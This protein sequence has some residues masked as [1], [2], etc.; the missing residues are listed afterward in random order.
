MPEAPHL[1]ISS[2]IVCRILDAAAA[3]GVD[4]MELYRAADIDPA[5]VRD[6]D[7]Q[8]GFDRYLRLWS[9]AIA[10]IDAPDFPLSVAGTWHR[11]HNLL[12]FVCMSSDDLGGALERASRYLR[13]V[14]NAV[15]WPVEQVGDVMVLSMDRGQASMTDTR[16]AEEFGAAEI[17]T[18]A[19]A[20]TGFDWNP[21]EVKFT[22]PEPLDASAHRTFFRGPVSFGHARC[23]IHF[24]MESLR[25]PLVKADPATVAFFVPYVEKL[26]RGCDAQ[27]TEK[28]LVDDVKRVLAERLRG[29]APALEEVAAA[30][31]MSGRTLRR[32]LQSD[33]HT[34][35]GLLDEVRLAI[36]KRHIEERAISLAEVA[37]LLGFS[38]PSAFHRAFR[39]WM[40]MTPQSYARTRSPTT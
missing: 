27:A 20:F 22:F 9:A 30:L 35:Q 16:P 29:S 37:F 21:V 17:V 18:L 12:R 15:S 19:R 26:L 28:T 6:V 4:P 33:G 14:T 3:R 31:S 39:R 1:V 11:T 5:H 38:E 23:E 34:F 10:R 25:L 2:R 24:S 7:A 32:R 13:V 36:A 40:G 8:I